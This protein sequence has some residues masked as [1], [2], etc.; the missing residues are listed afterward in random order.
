MTCRG[1]DPKA[2]KLPK[3]IKREA[4]NYTDAHQ[5]GLIIRSYVKILE[6]GNRQRNSRGNKTEK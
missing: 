1:Y 4:A 6:D 3:A 5:R 2:V